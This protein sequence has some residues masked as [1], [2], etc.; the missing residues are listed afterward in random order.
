MWSWALYCFWFL[1]TFYCLIQRER[2]VAFK[3]FWKKLVHECVNIKISN[4]ISVLLVMKWLFSSIRFAKITLNAFQMVWVD[5]ASM[6]MILSGQLFPE[7][8]IMCVHLPIFLYY[9][10][11]GSVH[12]LFFQLCSGLWQVGGYE[13]HIKRL[14]YLDTGRSE[15]QNQSAPGGSVTVLLWRMGGG[16]SFPYMLNLSLTGH[17][18]RNVTISVKWD[19]IDLGEK[20]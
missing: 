8:L 19:C 12:F 2:N 10:L 14:K 16:S 13:E 9:L 1:S 3:G 18:L 11:S 15:Y 6:V 7:L 5:L 4:W 20:S 17:S